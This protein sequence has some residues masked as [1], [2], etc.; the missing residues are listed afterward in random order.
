M[1]RF[2]F[3]FYEMAEKRL[4]LQACKIDERYLCCWNCFERK[5]VLLL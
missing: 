2:F 5:G 3:R 4:F 1:L